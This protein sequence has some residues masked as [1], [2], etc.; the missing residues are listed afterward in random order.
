MHCSYEHVENRIAGKNYI[1]L[2]PDVS[3]STTYIFR[4]HSELK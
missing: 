1:L 4:S 3:H 2:E